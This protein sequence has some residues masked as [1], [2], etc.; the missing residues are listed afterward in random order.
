[1][2][3]MSI[4][5]QSEV[6]VAWR[7]DF[8]VHSIRKWDDRAGYRAGWEAGDFLAGEQIGSKI[9]TFMCVYQIKTNSNMV[10]KNILHAKCFREKNR[11][12]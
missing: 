5:A 11:A 9:K 6:R 7:G 2:L 12:E 8:L 3:R 10:M 4:A 1:M